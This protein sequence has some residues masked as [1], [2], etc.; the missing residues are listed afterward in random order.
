MGTVKGLTSKLHSCTLIRIAAMVKVQYR[1]LNVSVVY[2][3]MLR[4]GQMGGFFYA[5]LLFISV[6]DF[7]KRILGGFMWKINIRS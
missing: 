4:H 1:L 7:K 5:Y 6:S 3:D 2:L